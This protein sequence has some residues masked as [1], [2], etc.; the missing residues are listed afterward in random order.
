MR[1]KKWYRCLI[2][3]TLNV[4][5]NNAWQLQKICNNENPLNMLQLRR[6]IVGTYLSQYGK[7]PEKG[8]RE[9]PQN[10]LS[11]I[12]YDGYNKHWVISQSGRTKCRHCHMK[13]TTRCEKCDVGML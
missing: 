5:I 2:S 7:P 9:K 13:T 1:G 4:S 12:R 10:I 11:D 8:M 6:Y 3:S